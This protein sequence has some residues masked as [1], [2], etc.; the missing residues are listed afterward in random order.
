M[1]K[2]PIR[3]NPSTDAA[4]IGAVGLTLLALLLAGCGKSSPLRSRLRA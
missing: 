2:T 4:R 1:R 3:S